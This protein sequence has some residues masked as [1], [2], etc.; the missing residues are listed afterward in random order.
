[1]NKR[2][3]QMLAIVVVVVGLLGFMKYRQISAAMAANKGFQMP[4]EAITTVVA[5]EA[6]WSATLEAVGSVAPVQ[7]VTLSADLAG[8]VDKVN[9]RS[10]AHVKAGQVLVTL[11]ARQERA[12]LASAEAKR[13]LAKVNL[14]RA[15]ALFEQK[16]IAQSDYDLAM[17]NFKTAEAAVAES[18]ASIDR[19]M[20][21]APFTG[22]TGIRQVNPGQYVNSGDPVVPLQAMDAVYV[23]FTVPQQSLSALRVGATVQATVEGSVKGTYQGRITAIDPVVN[24]ATRNVQVQATFPNPSGQLRPGM[25]ASVRAQVGKGEPTVALPTSAINYA[26]YGN[27]VFIVENMKGPDGKPYKGVRQQFVKLGRAQ[28]DQVA[29][30]EGVKPGQE[31][32]SSG[33]FKLRP[34]AAV[35]VDNKVMPS[36]S[37]APKPEDS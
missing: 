19:K 35:V 34:G 9:F 6:E 25:F 14:D 16:A 33:V 7:G 28:G 36:N 12:Q 26:P 20:I 31:I 13:D 1:M 4:P 29:I 27:S 10:G 32:V 2:M 21:R 17:A 24:D 11:D 23:D 22:T 3:I 18:Q 37:A 30:L 8:V 5:Q 15:R